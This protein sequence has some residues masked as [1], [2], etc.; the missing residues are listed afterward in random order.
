MKLGEYER[1]MVV[2]ALPE[3]AEGALIL[4]AVPA[5][6]SVRA[7]DLLQLENGAKVTAVIYQ[8][9]VDQEKLEGI[10]WAAKIDQV[11]TVTAIYDRQEVQWNG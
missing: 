11:P 2:A 6:E 3:D 7:G 10:V 5:R 4:C 9:Y 8:D 1:V